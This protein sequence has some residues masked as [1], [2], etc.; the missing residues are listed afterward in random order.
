[1][2]QTLSILFCLALAGV[3][4]GIRLAE[5]PAATDR[6]VPFS[7]G[8]LIGI[9]LFWVFPEVA[10]LYGWLS[11]IFG[12]LGGFALLWGINRFVHPVHDHDFQGFAPP[13]VA[14]ASVHSFFDGWSLAI[15]QQQ[16]S[17]GLKVA[18]MLGIGIH[19]IPEGLALGVLLLKATGSVWRSAANA[20]AIQ[21]CMGVGA[22][23]AIF[24][25]AHLAANWSS[26]LLA[27]A[28]GVFVYLGYHAIEGQLHHREFGSIMMP[29]LTGAAG[30]AV[31]RF[32][33]GF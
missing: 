1:M 5:I 10:E 26:L 9:A 3:A 25:A 20:I 29:A 18:V 23:A 32:V 6:I 19:K 30:A 11:G 15:A 27:S 33:P 2:V 22:L 13:L 28:A 17:G 21:S 12:A 24:L 4:V 7:G 31:L 16:S 14:A 8:L